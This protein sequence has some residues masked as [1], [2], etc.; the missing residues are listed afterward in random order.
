MIH[1]SDKSKCCG[2]EACVQVCPKSCISFSQD[3]EGFF[4]PEVDP[5]LCIDCGAC[6]NVCPEINQSTPIQPLHF[7]AAKNQDETIRMESSSG[8]IFTLL[9]ESIICEGGVVFGAKFNRK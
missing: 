4:Y 1:I 6:E 5:A 3:T 2:C 7:F 8:G 9:A